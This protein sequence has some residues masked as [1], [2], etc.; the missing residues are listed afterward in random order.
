MTRIVTGLFDN[1]GDA[2]RVVEHLVQELGIDARAVVA[3]AASPG[4]AVP[5]PDGSG[6]AAAPFVRLGLPPADHAA[7]L[8][9]LRRGGIVV[10]AQVEEAVLDRAM[11]AFEQN[12]A[13]DLDAREAEWRNA[14]WSSGYTGHDEDIGFA[15]YG[16][17]V[18]VGRIRR[19]H[20]DD[21][22]AGALGRLEI[23]TGEVVQQAM[24]RHR[25]R[26]RVRSFARDGG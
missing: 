6:T 3:H 5:P 9:G 19:H 22:P 18:V 21:M 8:E 2:E 23:S 15:T 17:D 1:R 16:Q 26:P 13:V 7:F 12:N 4:E 24:T 14:G 20:Q 11:D 10:S 25:I